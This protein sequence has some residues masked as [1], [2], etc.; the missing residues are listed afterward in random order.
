[1]RSPVPDGGE[2]RGD[3]GAGLGDGPGELVGPTLGVVL[4]ARV[5]AQIGQ[6]EFPAG[7]GDPAEADVVA[8]DLD[9]DQPVRRGQR[10][11]LGRLTSPVAVRWAWLRSR[12]SRR[13]S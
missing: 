11:Q 13:S 8:A 2:R 12:V 1:M 4:A 5:P 6:A 3:L 10:V 9:G 7:G